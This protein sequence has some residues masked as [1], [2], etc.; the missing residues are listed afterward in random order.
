MN[1]SLYA[2]SSVPAAVR[3]EKV[4][5]HPSRSLSEN[6]TPTAESPFWPFSPLIFV[7]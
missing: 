7:E 6:R 4:S 5:L 3:P 1:R 2:H